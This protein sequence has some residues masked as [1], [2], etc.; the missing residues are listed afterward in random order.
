[1]RCFSFVSVEVLRPIQTK[2]VMSCTVSLPDYTFAGQAL[3]SEW[4]VL[5]IFF[6]QK[7]KTAFSLVCCL[8]CIACHALI[9]LLL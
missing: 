2:W 8:L 3:S 9:A 4:L 5:C 6:R 7:L 1:M